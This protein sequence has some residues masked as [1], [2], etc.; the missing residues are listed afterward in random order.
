MRIILVAGVLLIGTHIGINLINN[1]S[2]MQDAKMQ[3]LCEVDSSYC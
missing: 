3:Q 2:D 1:V